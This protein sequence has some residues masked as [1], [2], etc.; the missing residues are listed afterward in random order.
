MKCFGS[1]FFILCDVNYR[2]FESL[3]KDNEQNHSLT[4]GRAT[5]VSLTPL[6]TPG[7]QD[8]CTKY[9]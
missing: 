7:V 9:K 4:R 5:Q 1:V 2:F 6:S 8:S 3:I